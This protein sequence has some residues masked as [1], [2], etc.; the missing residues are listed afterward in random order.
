MYPIYPP[1]TLIML[2]L[3]VY[4]RR[5]S[6]GSSK[7]Y[8]EQILYYFMYRVLITMRTGVWIP[9]TGD[10]NSSMG[11]GVDHGYWGTAEDSVS[12]SCGDYRY[13]RSTE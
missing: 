8:N 5:T 4:I 3:Q 6:N 11:Y 2:Y 7:C 12:W 10:Q 9:M 13:V 1:P